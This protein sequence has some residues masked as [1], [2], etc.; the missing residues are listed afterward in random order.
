MKAEEARTAILNGTAPENLEVSGWLYLTGC[1]GLTALPENLQVSGSLDL[2]DCT[3]LTA[4]QHTAARA[5]YKVI[6]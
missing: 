4:K 2:I 5:K 3:G 1:T 6:G